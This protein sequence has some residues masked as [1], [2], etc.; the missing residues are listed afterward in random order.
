MAKQQDMLLTSEGIKNYENEL[1]T[2]PKT[3]SMMKPKMNRLKWKQ[4]FPKLKIF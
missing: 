3:A 1:E 2:S 4:E